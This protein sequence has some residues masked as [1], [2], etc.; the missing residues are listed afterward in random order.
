VVMEG[1]NAVKNDSLFAR[2]AT[3]FGVVCL[4]CIAQDAC[5]AYC[6]G[7]GCDKM[8]PGFDK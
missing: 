5:I 1:S 2:N 3:G 6:G 4:E 8:T 7:L